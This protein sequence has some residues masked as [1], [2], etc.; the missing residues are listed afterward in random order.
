M[1]ADKPDL[2]RASFLMYVPSSAE[3]TVRSPVVSGVQHRQKQILPHP[4][5]KPPVAEERPTEDLSA[6]LYTLAEEFAN[7]PRPQVLPDGAYL[8]VTPSS[9]QL[10]S[11]ITN[12]RYDSSSYAQDRAERFHEYL[13]RLARTRTETIGKPLPNGTSKTLADYRR[14]Q[15]GEVSEQKPEVPRFSYSYNS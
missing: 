2:A 7:S 11:P 1:G 4:T 6:R 13:H 12:N 10:T 15:S 5:K 14:L 9:F 8:F 3:Q